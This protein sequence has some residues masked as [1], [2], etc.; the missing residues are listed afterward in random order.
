MGVSPRTV[1][2]WLNAYLAGGLTALRPGKDKGPPP[3][4]P[5]HLAPVIRPDGSSRDRPARGSTGPTGPVPGGPTTYARPTVSW[6]VLRPCN[7]SADDS[8]SGCTA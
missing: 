7:A 6:P 5:A 3:A 2:R 8:A 4:I 1:Q